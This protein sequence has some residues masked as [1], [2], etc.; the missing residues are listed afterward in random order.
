MHNIQLH[1]K[2][3]TGKYLQNL[4][5]LNIQLYRDHQ[6]T[7]LVQYRDCICLHAGMHWRTL[8]NVTMVKRR[9]LGAYNILSVV[10][11]QDA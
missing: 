11:K 4:P 9:L 10:S 2:D 7:L 1:T 8:G 3:V 5:F 6:A